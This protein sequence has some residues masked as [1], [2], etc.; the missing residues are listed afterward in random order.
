[1][2][3]MFDKQ[4]NAPKSATQSSAQRGGGTSSA[5]FASLTAGLMARKGE[6]SPAPAHLD[7]V[8]IHSHGVARVPETE[9]EQSLAQPAREQLFTGNPYHQPVPRPDALF[10][11]V[12][13]PTRAREQQRPSVD[14][15]QVVVDEEAQRHRAER[16]ATT[17]TGDCC[18]LALPFAV[19]E[20][21]PPGPY[22]KVVTRLDK[23]RV[24][25][26]KILA[27]RMETTNQKV[28]LAALDHYLDYACDVLARECPCL[29][30]S[31][32]EDV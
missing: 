7:G 14:E 30:R 3:R 9:Q 26:L 13:L 19:T 21:L 16:R 11:K 29:A 1:M 2:E 28:L 15:P 10:G 8:S 4:G 5:Q 25:K 24:R 18:A 31:M 27:A 12:H 22:A 20:T 23:E 17:S 32:R 6:A